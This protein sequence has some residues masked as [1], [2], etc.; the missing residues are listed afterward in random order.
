MLKS[1][2]GSGSCLVQGNQKYEGFIESASA[3]HLV[4]A[5]L[6]AASASFNFSKSTGP[7]SLDPRLRGG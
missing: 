7:C 3:R 4:L 2:S 6:Q 1:Q 5:A